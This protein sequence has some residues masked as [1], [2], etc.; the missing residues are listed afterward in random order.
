METDYIDPATGLAL[1]A[2]LTLVYGAIEVRIA[3][4]RARKAGRRG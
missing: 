1:A 2:A 4:R 3:R